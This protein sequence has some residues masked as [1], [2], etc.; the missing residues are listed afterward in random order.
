M[1]RARKQRFLKLWVQEFD[2]RRRGAHAENIMSFSLLHQVFRE[3][4]ILLYNKKLANSFR[5]ST[6]DVK[7]KHTAL[8]S[9]KRNVII[10]KF[11][12]MMKVRIEARQNKALMK[13]AFAALRDG[14]KLSGI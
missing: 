10:N 13:D 7:L 6:L 11:Q 9:F 2:K 8:Q 5:A 12:R 3:W 14:V 4:K 1:L